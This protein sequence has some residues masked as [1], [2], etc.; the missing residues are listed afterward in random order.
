MYLIPETVTRVPLFLLE[1]KTGSH[2]S[3]PGLGAIQT[4]AGDRIVPVEFGWH[5]GGFLSR[6]DNAALV[7]VHLVLKLS[8]LSLLLCRS[9]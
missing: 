7:R 6:V 5:G 1:R 4:G 9:P 8:A 2:R 3:S